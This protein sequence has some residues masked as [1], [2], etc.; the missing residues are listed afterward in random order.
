MN[1]YK[2]MQTR[3]RQKQKLRVRLGEGL[4]TALRPPYLGLLPIVALAALL[5]F[6]LS[7]RM[8]VF[9]TSVLP[10][11]LTIAADYIK[12]AAILTIFLVFLL[13]VLV[14][15]GTPYKWKAGEAA[16]LSAFKLQ[17]TPEECPL[18]I[19]SRRTKEGATRWEFFSQWVTMKEWQANIGDICHALDCHLVGQ[20][21]YGGKHRNDC[22]RVVFYTKKGATSNARGGLKDSDF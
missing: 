6:A 14:L 4:N 17:T 13:S 21:E 16:A 8:A 7:N 22:H 3:N 20:I 10:E 18:L 11:Q 15:L 5:Y 1:D 19:S 12:I 2:Q 9:N